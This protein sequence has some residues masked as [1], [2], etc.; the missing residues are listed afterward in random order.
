VSVSGPA[1]RRVGLRNETEQYRISDVVDFV[2]PIRVTSISSITPNGGA[3]R[4]PATT[5]WP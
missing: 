2:D 5:M 3:H 4:R 1:D